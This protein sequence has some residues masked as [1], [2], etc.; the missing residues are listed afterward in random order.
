MSLSQRH[1]GHVSMKP[2]E[3][4]LRRKVFW[5][6]YSLDRMLALAL[7][8]PLGIEDSDCDADYPAEYDDDEL[9]DYFSGANMQKPQPSLMMGFIALVDLYKIAGRLCRQIYGIDKCGDHLEPNVLQETVDQAKRLD[10]EL[11]DWCNR[12]P[13][14]FKSTPTTEEQV[15]MGAVLCSHY[16]SILTTLHRNF[17]PI[18]Q[19]NYTGQASSLK[20]VHS[21]RS[22]I[23][24]A[25]SVKNV[26]PSSHH[27]A[28][29]IQ[30]LF[31][32]AVI[33]LLYAMHIPDKDAAHAAMLEAESCMGV[34][35][36][37]E[38][39]WPGARKCKELLSD[40]ANTARDAIDQGPAPQRTH[41]SASPPFSVGSPSSP[42]R[43]T[44]L[45]RSLSGRVVKNK[46]TRGKSRDSLRDPRDR[47]RTRSLSVQRSRSSAP[48]LAGAGGSRSLYQIDILLINT[49]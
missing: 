24:L 13:T 43:S 6:V 48:G 4:Q 28:L 1:S 21:A 11:V 34:V 12:L 46:H 31:S 32:S 3:K 26:V 30:H 45:S 39:I 7:G 18:S 9:P 16:Y 37:W 25:P 49:I 10:N 33:I 42:P 8:R 35:S 5:C 23:R 20:A 27:L 2:I 22:C 38:G 36:G 17:L 15:T 19:S 29:F 40:L 14:T 44:H 41:Q 47:E